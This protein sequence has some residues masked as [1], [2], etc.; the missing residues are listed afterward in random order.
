MKYNKQCLV[1]FLLAPIV[2][3]TGCTRHVSRGLTAEGTVEEAVFPDERYLVQKAGSVP[4]PDHVRLVAPGLTKA[5]LRGL[6]GS[7]H[8]REGYGAR[9]WDYL[10]HLQAP[11]GQ[12][13]Q[14]RFKVV[15]DDKSLARSLF[16]APTTCADLL[17][18]APAPT[19]PASEER[20]VSLS[21]DTLFAYGK[22]STRD[23]TRHGRTRVEQ[24]AA[25]LRGA[26]GLQVQLLGYTD[27]IGTTEANQL[28]SQRRADSVRE[29]LISAGILAAAIVARGL[30]ESASADC[31]ERLPRAEQIACMAPDRR[32]EILAQGQR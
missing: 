21:T 7:P 18:V 13:Q 14:C 5:Q 15:F 20:R 27:R 31:S 29:V 9:E 2:L 30:G 17:A 28:L 1:L 25:E 23:M 3:A 4:K 16:W 22:W 26:D 24:V 10:F 11:D 32:V 12:M 19:R 8:F 6:I